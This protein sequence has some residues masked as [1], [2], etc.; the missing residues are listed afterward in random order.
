M[1]DNLSTM[2]PGTRAVLDALIALGHATAHQLSERSGKA[3]STTDRAIKTLTDAGLIVAVDADADAAKGTTTRWTLSE[4]VAPETQERDISADTEP[5]AADP[6][7]DN[8]DSSGVVETDA[9]HTAPA[10]NGHTDDPAS[11]GPQPDGKPSSA[12]VG[13]HLADEDDPRDADDHDR[14]GTDADSDEG[15]PA[16]DRI[17]AAQ[18]SRPGDRKV[19]TI[20]AVLSEHGVDGATISQIVA[21]SGIGEATASRLLAAMEQVDAA[22]RLPGLPQRWIAGPTKANEVDPN[23]QPPRCPLCFH[24]IKG[25]SAPEAVAQVQPLVRPDGMLHIVAE[26]GTVHAVALPTRP[27]TRTAGTPRTD[28]VNTDGSQPFARG[29]LERLT[30]ETLKANPGRTMTPQEIT[31]AI[32][33]RLGGRAV[34]PGAVRNNCGKLGAAGRIVMVSESPWAFQYPAQTDDGATDQPDNATAER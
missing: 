17:S 26:D 24:V 1:Q 3:R 14:S 10:T 2:T 32:S 4:K 9:P 13:Q 11:H 22:R 8:E 16:G 5:D 25:L 19:M 33:N 15:D 30:F 31:V 21:E 28:T 20:K 7:R 27:P 6:A 29:E 34:S 18:A 12:D 23:P